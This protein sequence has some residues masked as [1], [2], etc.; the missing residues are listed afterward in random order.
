MERFAWN[1]YYRLKT[2]S[3][4]LP[5]LREHPADIRMLAEHFV[6]KHKKHATHL[7]PQTL[8]LLQDYAWPGNVQE[9]ESAMKYACLF[10]DSA[11]ILPSH[12]PEG[13]QGPQPDIQPN[14]KYLE[15]GFPEK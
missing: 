3:I 10:A 14:P 9:L 11:V 6:A 2:V 13:F 12:L 15:T 7:A 1:L 5:P 4:T 8:T